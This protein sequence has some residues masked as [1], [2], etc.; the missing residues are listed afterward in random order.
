AAEMCAVVGD[1]PQVV[2][3]GDVPGEVAVDPD[4]G[5]Q[6]GRVQGPPGGGHRGP[7]PL[8]PVGGR[9]VGL[10]G[11]DLG[12]VA[13]QAGFGR[14]QLVVLGGDDHGEPVAGE[15]AGQLQPDPA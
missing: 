1:Q 7:Q 12:A 9:Q 10:D 2:L 13:G 3:E 11:P 5:V 6:G 8:H 14:G 4:P 15:L